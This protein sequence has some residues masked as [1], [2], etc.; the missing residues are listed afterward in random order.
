MASEM[1]VLVKAGFVSVDEIDGALIV[2]FAH[3]QSDSSA[4][5]ALERGLDPE[6]DD[7]ALPGSTVTRPTG[8]HGRMSGLGGGGPNKS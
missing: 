5:F 8:A 4:Y 1:Q 7:G 3:H 6:D 2:G